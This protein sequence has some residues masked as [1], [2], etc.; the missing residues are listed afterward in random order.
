MARP[1]ARDRG[2]VADKEGSCEQIER[3]VAD[4][5]RGV[6]LQLGGWARC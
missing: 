3:A 1:Q 2:T 4:S 5:R 6:I